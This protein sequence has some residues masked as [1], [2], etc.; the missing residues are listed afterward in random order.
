M[1]DVLA[2]ILAAGAAER[3]TGPTLKQLLWVAG[4]TLLQRLVRQ[5]HARGARVVVVT[6]DDRLVVPDVARLSPVRHGYLAET[7]ASAAPEWAPVD[8]V[9][10][11]CGDVV[12]S[13]AAADA[14]FTTDRQAVFFGNIHEI[15]AVASRAPH[16]DLLRALALA[17]ADTWMGGRGKL[18][19]VYRA[20]AGI[21]LMEHRLEDAF[22]QVVDDW[23]T[24]FDDMETWTRFSVGGQSV[25][26]RLP[27]FLSG[28]G[29]VGSRVIQG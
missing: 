7:L 21:P 4:E 5:A 15:Y 19:Q 18:W 29:A 26:D 1:S 11:L 25:D 14:V 23:T 20:M 27:G 10:V 24:D 28:S 16:L 12:L 8:K 3:W 13:K 17:I 22:F 6:H 2:V 9:V